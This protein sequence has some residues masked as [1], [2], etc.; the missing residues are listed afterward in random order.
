M[1]HYQSHPSVHG[2]LSVLVLCLL[3]LSI[4]YFLFVVVALKFSVCPTVYSLAQQLYLQIFIPM[5]YW[6]ALPS[7]LNRQ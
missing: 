2:Q 6:S 3:G 5:S 4:T 7:I 1:L